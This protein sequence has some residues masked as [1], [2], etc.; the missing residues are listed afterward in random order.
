MVVAPIHKKGLAV[1]LG[2]SLFEVFG[3]TK[4]EIPHMDNNIVVFYYAVV[5]A[6]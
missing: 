2:Y 6:N 3:F 5:V 1:E 4:R